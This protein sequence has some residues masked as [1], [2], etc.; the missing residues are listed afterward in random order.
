MK[1][2]YYSPVPAEDS[3]SLLR[4]L[5][6]DDPQAAEFRKKGSFARPISVSISEV[7]H[8]IIPSNSPGLTTFLLINTMIGSGILNQPFV[9]MTSGVIGASVSYVIAAY[10]TWVGLML[11]TEVGNHVKVYEYSGLAHKI[12]GKNGERIVDIS[13][14]LFAF[15]ALL[16]YIVV[17]GDTLSNLFQSWGCESEYCGNFWITL[18]TVTFLVTPFCLI[19][20]FGHFAWL[21]VFS[22]ATIVAVLLLVLIGGP[23]KQERGEVRLFDVAGTLQCMGSI[24][25][26]LACAP[27]NFQAYVSTETEFQTPKAWRGITGGAV[28]IG[29]LM[30]AAMGI[31][32]YLA[33]RGE[34]EGEILGESPACIESMLL[35][36]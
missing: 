22:I 32:G 30:C 12:Y 18:L 33:F 4:P 13:I 31:G 14:I 8:N 11:L 10:A 25:F 5:S 36:I 2:T 23:L 34:T 19:R 9:F 28:G 6:G 29:S 20:H 26:S 27:A 7:I 21:S 17:V 16:G 24:V 35:C 3:R 1:D 15:G